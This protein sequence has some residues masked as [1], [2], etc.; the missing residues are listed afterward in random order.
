MHIC[1]LNMPIEYYSPTSGGAISTIIMQ[2]ARD[3]IARGHQVTILTR[4]G[5]D[6]SYAVG[7]VV[8]LPLP[9]REMLGPVRRLF[10]RFRAKFSQWDWPYYEYYVSAFSNALRDLPVPPDAVVVRVRATRT[11]RGDLGRSDDRRVDRRA[12]LDALG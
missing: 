4:M 10:S 3:L 1:F 7:N 12:A 5:D 6:D 11:D 2:T 9:S 8:P